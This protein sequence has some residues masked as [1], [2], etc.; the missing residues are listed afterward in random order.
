MS[1][2]FLRIVIPWFW[3]CG[4]QLRHGEGHA[5][6][7]HHQGRVH[8]GADIEGDGQR[9]RAVVAHLRGHVEHALDAVDLLLDRRRHRV[10]H[11]RGA[12]PGVVDGHRHAGRRDPGI[13]RHRQPVERDPADQGDDDGQNRREDR[14]IDEE[15]RD[16]GRRPL[17]RLAFSGVGD[18]G[19]L[20]YGRRWIGRGRLAERRHGHPLR[21]D[22]HPR[23]D[24]QHSAA[25]DPVVRLQPLLD[26]PQAVVLE[27][28]RRDPAG[29]D[30]VFGIEHVDVLQPLVRRNGPIDDQE[31]P[32]GYADRQADPHEHAG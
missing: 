26:H 31:R 19:V 3:T 12:G 25:D 8:V 32:V 28:A 14:S 22:H 7:H 23:P 15:A 21:P 18:A 13:L 2:V 5:V 10:G 6:L 4:R 30:L 29:L 24:L 16:H 27:R 9:V 17:E 11:H 1:G 20:A